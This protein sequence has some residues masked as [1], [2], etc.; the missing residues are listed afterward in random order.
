MERVYRFRVMDSRQFPDPVHREITTHY[1]LVP[2]RD[3]PGDIATDA[4]A[5]TPNTSKRIYKGILR[6]LQNLDDSPENTFHLKNRG[7][8]IIANRVVKVNQ[9]EFDVHLDPEMSQGIVDGGHTYQIIQEAKQIEQTV[10][11]PRLPDRQL[12]M[13]EVREGVSSS[14]VVDISRGLNTSM[15]VKEMSLDNLAGQFQWIKDIISDE[16]YADEIAWSENEEGKHDAIDILRMMVCLNVQLFPL[17]SRTQPT[18]AYSSKQSVLD[19]YH[20]KPG[21]FKKMGSMLKDIL[22]FY[23]TIQVSG[24]T[25]Y[26]EFKRSN[27]VKS[28]KFFKHK[29]RFYNYPFAGVDEQDYELH[30]GA[31]FPIL[32]AFRP[33]VCQATENSEMQWKGGFESV[34]RAWQGIGG[35]LIYETDQSFKEM[36]DNIQTVGKSRLHWGKMLDMV[37]LHQQQN[38]M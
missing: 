3:M 31:V 8:T 5:R 21:S 28:L 35:E 27:A 26:N 14:W 19:S 15:Q 12:V 29:P 30:R 36:S 32:A 10:G 25:L 24:P 4:N 20:K 23:D 9:N 6:S 13:V 37:R 34:N 1:L 16:S 22:S 33:Y 18:I 11:E 2:A 38:G 17:D 7:I